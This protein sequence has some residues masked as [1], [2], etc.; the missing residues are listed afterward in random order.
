MANSSSEKLVKKS[1][2]RKFSKID[3]NIKTIFLMLKWNI[4]FGGNQII[5]VH[6]P[7]KKNRS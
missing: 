3:K 1:F 5:R 6:L 7:I 4:Q 2:L